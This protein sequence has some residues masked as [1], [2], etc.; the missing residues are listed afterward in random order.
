[1]LFVQRVGEMGEKTNGMAN[2]KLSCCAGKDEFTKNV[3][4]GETFLR[5]N[6]LCFRCLLRQ[7]L[8]SHQMVGH[9]WLNGNRHG[10][11]V[12]IGRRGI[13]SKCVEHTI[14]AGLAAQLD[15]VS[16]LEDVNVIA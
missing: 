7:T 6:L 9:S 12:F 10:T 15:A 4:V 2:V 14:N 11:F 5:N 3:S 1:M 8:E 13:P 16:S